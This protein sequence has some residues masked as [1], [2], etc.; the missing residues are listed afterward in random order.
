[1]WD[2]PE[3]LKQIRS[4]I[5]ICIS[6]FKSVYYWLCWMPW[7]LQPHYGSLDGF[8]FCIVSI[9]SLECHDL[10]ADSRYAWEVSME[11]EKKGRCTLSR[12]FSDVIDDEQKRA[13]L[14]PGVWRALFLS[15]T[16][17]PTVPKC[18]EDNLL[19]KYY[20]R[21]IFIIHCGSKRIEHLILL[22]EWIFKSVQESVKN[23]PKEANPCCWEMR[24]Q[25]SLGTFSPLWVYS[26]WK[27]LL[28]HLGLNIF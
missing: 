7:L 22:I 2:R 17:T 25:K 12:K 1:M 27:L 10:N 8:W 24:S 5:F 26:H 14:F 19:F 9:W 13:V 3:L 23:A 15:H 16:L 4:L 18:M 20:R 6:T 11:K 21:P 28:S